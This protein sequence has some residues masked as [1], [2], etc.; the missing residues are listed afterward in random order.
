MSDDKCMS[1]NENTLRC[2]EYYEKRFAS[3]IINAPSRR[4]WIEKDRLEIISTL[5]ECLGFKE[6][7]IP[8]IK[9]TVVKVLQQDGFHIEFLR[10]E[11]WSN[12]FGAAHLYVPDDNTGLYT[13]D[14]GIQR[15]FVLLCCGHGAYCKL[16]PG[17]QAMA[18]R[19]ARQG[20]MVLITDNIGQGERAPMGHADVALPFACGLSLQGLI[21]METIA[22]VRWAMKY[23]RVDTGRM[24][25]IG[26][27]GGGTL[28][29]LLSGLCPELAVMSASGYP[30]TFEYLAKKE[31]KHCHCNILPG[32]IGKVDMWEILGTF[33][34]KP[35][36]IFQGMDDNMLPNDIFYSVARK[37]KTVYT[38]L[39]AEDAFRFKS[40]NGPHSWTNEKRYHLARFLADTLKLL[41][42]K[43]LEDDTV[44]CIDV[45]NTCYE[46]WPKEAIT[47]DELAVH[48]TGINPDPGL[49]LYDVY[50][51][52]FD[53][54]TYDQ[55]GFRGETRQ[56]FA[57]Y[58][59]F[60]GK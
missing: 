37:V 9:A 55:K 38:E 14:N 57:Q 34:P 33:A 10:S 31:K 59:A 5:K 40:L 53:E 12:V 36:Y 49:K 45:N 21:V 18:R 27:S 56:V 26:N 6:E 42:A 2:Y 7:Y 54:S 1:I 22:W 43:V 50:K 60:L 3:A 4:P 25:S 15:P 19:L 17:Y 20:A 48:L 32:V 8:E 46:E 13:S 41:P 44:D 39:N 58:E 23:N 11:S 52:P 28:S 47:A 30:S 24:A 29:L 51:P 16:A 35:M